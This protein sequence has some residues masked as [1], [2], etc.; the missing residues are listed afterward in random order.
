MIGD[1]QQGEWDLTINACATSSSAAG[2]AAA[3]G[4]GTAISTEG[5]LG[6][7]IFGNG[8]KATLSAEGTL[9]FSGDI[10]AGVELAV[11][12]CIRGA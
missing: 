12:A 10:G 2:M 6:A 4:I 9:G 1:H 11:S 3:L 5:M 7:D 8:A